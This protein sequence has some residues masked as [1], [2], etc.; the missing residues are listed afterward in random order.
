MAQNHTLFLACTRPALFYGIPIEAA[1]ASLFFCGGTFLISGF[2]AP[3]SLWRAGWL[4]GAAI[5]CY[6]VCRVAAARDHNIFHI[7]S[8]WA[9][10]KG[11]SRP[12]F[13]YWGG[14][15]RSPMPL[16]R[17][18]KAGEIPFLG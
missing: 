4:F 6:L 12:N 1:V 17:A 14:S 13:A 3:T 5:A 8:V 2:I 18:R 9:V 11:R 7:L 10:T 15:S 16:R